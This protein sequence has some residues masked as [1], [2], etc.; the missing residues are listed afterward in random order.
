MRVNSS[1]TRWKR[2]SIASKRSSCSSSVEPLVNSVEFTEHHR[3][4][5]S[6]S[7]SAIRVVIARGYL[8]VFGRGVHGNWRRGVARGF[9]WVHERASARLSRGGFAGLSAFV[10]GKKAFSENELVADIAGSKGVRVQL[11]ESGPCLRGKAGAW[12]RR[13]VVA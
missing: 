3:V 7:V 2:R 11:N 1:S 6:K 4:R 10:K 8:T 5:R 12:I 9:W 13:V